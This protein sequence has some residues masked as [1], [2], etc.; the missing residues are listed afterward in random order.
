MKQL[1]IS[2][3][4]IYSITEED[5]RAFLARLD[6][7]LSPRSPDALYDMFGSLG[8]SS[9]SLVLDA[10]CRS[11]AQ[12]C[13][14][15]QRFG[16]RVV[17]VDLVEMNIREAQVQIAE[18]GFEGSVQAILGDLQHL[19][20][21]DETFDFIW[22]RDVLLH[23]PDLQQT[24]S[25]FARVLKPGG[26][27]LLFSVFATDLLTAEEADVIIKEPANIRENMQQPYFEGA[28]NAAGLSLVEK[29]V[30]GSE[31]YE[32]LEETNANMTSKQLLR[33]A[34]LRRNREQYIAEFGEKRYRMELSNCHY[35]V[36]QMLGKL[37][38]IVY[39]LTKLSN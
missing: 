38:P 5:Y 19:E 12:A 4:D 26:K 15:F 27:M 29:D 32:H 18:K 7:S 35:G 39:T 2:V 3:E 31:W 8:P 10:G 13:E 20:F 16:S 21:E 17:G 25:E 6:E 11:A 28:F 23:M 33:I 22:C 30:V 1:R 9:D 24:F 36:Y 14:I 34:R 37:C